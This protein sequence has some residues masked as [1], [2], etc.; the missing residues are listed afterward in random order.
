[1]K[2]AGR[3]VNKLS[4]N[5]RVPFASQAHLAFAGKHKVDLFLI[6]IVPRDLSSVRFKINET[7]AEV[8]A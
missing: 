2:F 6:L 3:D 7:H 1:M 5:E 8:F 4:R